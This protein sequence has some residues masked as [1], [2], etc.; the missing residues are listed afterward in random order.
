MSILS[1][2]AIFFIV[3]SLGRGIT[4]ILASQFEALKPP[5]DLF[6]PK[7]KE[8]KD[9]SLSEREKRRMKKNHPFLS[10]DLP[11]G[12]SF[13]D[14]LARAGEVLSNM[15]LDQE[16]VR[17]LPR[18]KKMG[19]FK[20]S[21]GQDGSV[22]VT[23]KDQPL[24]N[25]ARKED[26]VFHAV[27]YPLD[28]DSFRSRKEYEQVESMSYALRDASNPLNMF[29]REIFESELLDG[30]KGSLISLTAAQET[31]QPKGGEEERAAGEEDSLGEEVRE[32]V[33]NGLLHGNREVLF[34]G[35]GERDVLDSKGFRKAVYDETGLMPQE[36]Q[37]LRRIGPES[38]FF[39]IMAEP[40]SITLSYKGQPIV[41]LGE[42]DVVRNE[43]GNIES[44]DYAMKVFPPEAMEG[45]TGDDLM[46]MGHVYRDFASMAGRDDVTLGEVK[47]AMRQIM[48]TDGNLTA[49]RPAVAREVRRI[50]RE[51]V[52]R[53]AKQ[54]KAE[55][56]RGVRI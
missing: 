1:I 56:S 30:I 5:Q 4:R 9:F 14:T 6:T 46:K 36:F 49:L 53:A 51:K 41:V 27:H 10:R 19:D 24:L 44:R 52:R 7:K 26:G 37:L 11:E 43:D 31:V 23:Y 22:L 28:A 21:E 15:G 55:Q 12:F 8:K 33:E 54:Q 40:D 17:Q 38:A 47:Y 25:V 35:D 29:Y 34:S 32:Y 18:L 3:R 13:G 2:I 50:E 16:L 39:S 48:C 45:F 20:V 42:T